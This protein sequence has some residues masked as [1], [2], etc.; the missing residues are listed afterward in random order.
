[1]SHDEA[2]HPWAPAAD[3]AAEIARLAA[4]A[5]G[6]VHES[7]EEAR[8]DGAADLAISGARTVE[9]TLDD[10]EIARLAAL[11]PIQCDRELPV[12]AKSLRCQ[13]STLRAAVKAGRAAE[14]AKGAGSKDADTTGQGQPLN[15]ADIEPWPESIDG[16]ALLTSIA[17]AIRGYVVLDTA[18]ADAAALWVVHTHAIAAAYVTPRLAITSPEKRCGKTTLLTLLGALVARPQPAANMT[19]ATLFRV[20]T[21]AHPTVL[22]DEADTFLRDNEELR[23]VINAGHCRANAEV[24]RTVETRDRHEVRKF[25]VFGPMAIAAIGKLPGTIEDRAIKI[26]MRRRR[27]DEAVGRLRLDRLGEFTPLPRGMARWV[28]DYLAVLRAADPAVPAALHDRAADNWRPLLAIAD[29]A[30]GEWPERARKAAVALTLAG[31]EDAETMRTMLLRDLRAM[32]EAVPADPNADPPVIARAAREVLFTSEILDDLHK[33]DDRPWPEWGKASKPITSRQLAALLKP[34]K[35]STNQTVRRGA[36]HGKGYR[37]ADFADA[38]ARYATRL[39]IGDTVTPCTNPGD[40]APPTGDKAGAMSPIRTARKPGNPPL[41]TMSLM[42]SPR[43]A[44]MAIRMYRNRHIRRRIRLLRSR[45]RCRY[46]GAF[47]AHRG[48]RCRWPFRGARRS[49]SP[50]R[51]RDPASHRCRECSCRGARL[52]P[53]P[54]RSPGPPPRSAPR[55]RGDGDRLGRDGEPLA[56]TSRGE[57]SGMDMRRVRRADRRARGADARGQQPGAS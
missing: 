13:V 9:I 35:I 10:A 16:N 53:A 46:E 52:A 41:V 42:E 7:R 25:E 34:L 12:A 17:E 18:A 33:R 37:A 21:A 54:S 45:G 56:P 29:L 31:A 50:D 30:G 20:I 39:S 2:P 15:I 49:A 8:A 3:S 32:F 24:L 48:R 19:V 57:G 51:A 5:G 22:V 1:M 27:P 38:F 23:G 26:A 43:R 55:E 4:L 40:F 14:S 6:Q 28:A 47:A 44:R 36:D 11:P